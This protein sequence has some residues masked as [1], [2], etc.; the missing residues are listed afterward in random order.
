MDFTQVTQVN[1]NTFMVVLVRDPYATVYVGDIVAVRVP[2]CAL[3][4]S[5]GLC[6]SRHEIL[7]AFS[8]QLRPP[9]SLFCAVWCP[10]GTPYSMVYV[11]DIVAVRIPPL[12]VCF[13]KE[14]DAHR[15]SLL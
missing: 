6:T 14:C 10:C 2:T 13:S 15:S 1:T 12:P 4:T 8:S 5:H 3:C 9:V 11:G 7:P